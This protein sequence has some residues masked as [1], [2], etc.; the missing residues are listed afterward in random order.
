[1]T[2]ID[3]HLEQIRM[4]GER[5]AN[6]PKC[7]DPIATQFN[8]QIRKIRQDSRS[9]FYQDSVDVLCDILEDLN[10]KIAELEKK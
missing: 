5:C 4:Y 10:R 3:I 6:A 7:S 8:E 9:G 1:M 2:P